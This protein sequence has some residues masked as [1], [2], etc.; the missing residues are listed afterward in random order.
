MTMWQFVIYGIIGIILMGVVATKPKYFW[1]ILVI[2][3]VGTVGMM[4]GGRYTFLD[5]YLIGCILF[6]SL[7]AIS[8]G[9]L[10]FRKSRE[11]TWDHLHKW[12][13]LLMIIYMIVQSLRGL[14]VLESLRK[15]RWIVY[16]GMLGIIMF[17]ISN[18]GFPVPSNRK[19][20]L[21][22]SSTIL[23]YLIFYIAYGLFS[24]IVNGISRWNLQCTEWGS[25]AYSFFPLV[26]AIPAAIFLLKDRNRVYQRVGLATLITVA[27]A[28]FY[29]NS[30]VSWLVIFGFLV[31]SLFKLGVRKVTLIIFSFLVIF[32]L[33]FG[34]SDRIEL[35]KEASSFFGELSRTIQGINFWDAS[36]KTDIL[37]KTHLKVGFINIMENWK[38]LLF[39]H[40][41]RVHGFVIGPDL[42][43]IYAQYNYPQ[44]A[45]RVGDTVSTE[46]F[47][48]LLVDTGLVGMM[49]LVINF[50]LVARKIFV[51]KRNP[52]KN[53]L[54]LSLIF[55][56]L[57]L[58]VIN[59]VDIMLF[60][61]LIM[62][63]GL[64]VQLSQMRTGGIVL[65]GR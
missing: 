8:M 53:I 21:I 11:N 41:F 47:T 56:F 4:V 63:K 38:T 15:I 35:G 49:L 28:A 16:Y 46:G 32:S 45:A 40:G 5:E 43:K 18:K 34:T 58:T 31:V 23:G 42:R 29:Y 9:T 54:L 39:G 20:S 61:F 36:A 64:L 50:L 52:N 65:N 19:I 25:T 1:P 22:V 7:L 33:Y 48:A 17:M 57:W 6:G 2:V 13:F 24:E 44:F 51:Q 12:V 59:M 62:P 60:Y 30:R 27:L 3:S 10:T 26:I 55:A 14:I 37:R